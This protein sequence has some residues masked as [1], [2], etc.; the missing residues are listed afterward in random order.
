[1][2]HRFFNNPAKYTFVF[3]FQNPTV[4]HQTCRFLVRPLIHW[5]SDGHWQEGLWVAMWFNTDPFLAWVSQS[6]QS[7]DR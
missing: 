6:K 4:V 1:M 3:L 5:D 2:Q 7:S